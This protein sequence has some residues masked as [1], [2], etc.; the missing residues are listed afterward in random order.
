MAWTFA[1]CLLVGI[2]EEMMFRGVLLSSFTKSWGFKKAAIAVA[3]IF[4]LVHI[5]NAL[6]TGK[7]GE[8]F[9]QAFMALVSILFIAYRV[10]NLTIV[11]AIL[12]HAVGICSFY[13]CQ[14]L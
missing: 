11:F 4:G 6:T 8:G 9:L 5:L 1:N 12:M 10:K 2:S 13:F 7:L 3:V 14:I